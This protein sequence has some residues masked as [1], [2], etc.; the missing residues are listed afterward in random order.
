MKIIITNHAY[1]KAAERLSMNEKDFRIEAALAYCYG[2]MP[3]DM[4]PRL[5]DYL[6]RRLQ[7]HG[8]TDCRIYNKNVFIYTGSR[9]VT[10]F[11]LNAN[12]QMHLPKTNRS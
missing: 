1:Q 11:P 9:L 5:Q 6:K 12:M 8:N 2:L 3:L 10:V 4:A 7:E